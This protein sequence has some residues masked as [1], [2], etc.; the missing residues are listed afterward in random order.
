MRSSKELIGKPIFSLTDGRHQG[1]VK[2]LYVDSELLSIVGI[3]LGS[4]GLFSR[5]ARLI[6]AENVSV[7]GYDAVLTI[8]TDLIKDDE[9]YVPAQ[10]WLRRDNVLGRMMHTSGGTKVGTVGDLLLDDNSGVIGF[11]LDRILVEGPIAR[12]RMIAR[13]AVLDAGGFEG[14]I[15]VDLAR[16]EQ[17]PTDTAADKPAASPEPVMEPDENGDVSDQNTNDGNDD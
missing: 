14:S 7:F 15:I 12:N 10:T 11:S 16:A 3:F 13:S 9:N 6:P 2:D 4:E 8:G 5:K 1:V 17:P